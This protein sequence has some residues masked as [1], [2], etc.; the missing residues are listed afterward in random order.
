MKVDS[1][2]KFSSRGLIEKNIDD[3]RDYS[4][5][6]NDDQ[7]IVLVVGD[8]GTSKTSL[9]L[10]LEHYITRGDVNLDTY[11]LTHDEFIQQYTSRPREKIIVYEEGRNSF[12]KNK[13]NHNST[14]EARDK[15]NQFRKFHHT[16][17]INFQNP[18]HL[19]REIVRNGNCILR[20]PRRGTVE[21]YNRDKLRS[22]WD[23]NEF[24]GWC[25]YN[26]KDFFPDPENYVPNIW[27]SYE[28]KSLDAL[29]EKGAEPD[30]ESDDGD[31]SEEH[32]SVGDAADMLGLSN[33]T[34][35]RYCDNGKLDFKRPNKQRRIEES[36]VEKILEDEDAEE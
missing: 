7:F 28:Q 29:D 9:S 20:T 31:S 33:S 30:K 8:T 23:G 34:V 11:A 3:Y 21:F 32:L 6:K 17:F 14:A 35:R 16:V 26:F 13:Y 10:L 27:S 25:N 2:Y 36:S 19:T 18:N 5:K 4:I 24:K 22:M 1:E 12:D 15:I